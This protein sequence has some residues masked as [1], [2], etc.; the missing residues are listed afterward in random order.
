M[1]NIMGLLIILIMAN[2]TLIQG[3]LSARGDREEME[4]RNMHHNTN[5]NKNMN[6]SQAYHHPNN[7][8]QGNKAVV[9]P[10]NQQQQQPVYV[11]S[12]D[13]SAPYLPPNQ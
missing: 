13:N 2:I 10:G 12:P 5:I 8:E 1:K 7:L 4:H 9:V 3:N 11:P 6:Y